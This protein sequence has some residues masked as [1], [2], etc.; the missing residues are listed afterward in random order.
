M[1]ILRGDST[2]CQ[3]FCRVLDENSQRY[4]ISRLINSNDYLRPS[5]LTG[6]YCYCALLDLKYERG[7]QIDTILLLI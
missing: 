2:H 3:I 7:V 6:L 5:A 1:S 4:E